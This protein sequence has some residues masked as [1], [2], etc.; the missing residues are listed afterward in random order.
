[1]EML[2]AANLTRKYTKPVSATKQP[3]NWQLWFYKIL[4]L[5]SLSTALSNCSKAI[6]WSK[7][8]F[9]GELGLRL[10]QRG[11]CPTESDHPMA[12]GQRCW[13]TFT[14]L[15]HSR[16]PGLGEIWY[17][18]PNTHRQKMERQGFN[19]SGAQIC[20]AHFKWTRCHRYTLRWYYWGL[21]SSRA[22]IET[23]TSKLIEDIFI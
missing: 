9:H 21:N 8:G 10:F 12:G 23:Y 1:M 18:V 5:I 13:Y 19:S 11:R 22:T 3:L 7:G 4:S 2:A 15:L 16:P 14:H 20:V 17:G 6:K